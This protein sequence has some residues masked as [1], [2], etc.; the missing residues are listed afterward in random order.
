MEKRFWIISILLAISLH[1]AVQSTTDCPPG[2]VWVNCY[3]DCVS[4]CQE[5]I[6]KR[7]CG[8]GCFCPDDSIEINGTCLLRTEFCPLNAP[9]QH[10]WTDCK[11]YSETTCLE[12]DVSRTDCV[13]GYFCEDP[14]LIS[15]DGECVNKIEHCEKNQ[16]YDQVD[17][18]HSVY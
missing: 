6:C 1:S 17:W 14:E 2:K 3:M 18:S 5:T 11:S 4:S 15:V 16:G 13:K 10:Y 8:R 12:E 7:T 9:A